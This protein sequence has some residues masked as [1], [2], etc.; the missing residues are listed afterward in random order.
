MD[1]VSTDSV[2][3]RGKPLCIC[4]RYALRCRDTVSKSRTTKNRCSIPIRIV[5]RGQP[6]DIGLTPNTGN[7]VAETGGSRDGKTSSYS[8]ATRGAAR[9]S[10]EES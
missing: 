8:S 1:S 7:V 9:S 10:T 3:S 2:R 5:S 4:S 6:L